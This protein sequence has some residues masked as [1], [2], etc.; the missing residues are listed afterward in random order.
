MSSDSN[1]TWVCALEDVA[2]LRFGGADTLAF[3]QTKLAADT[4][5]WRMNGGGYSVAT[6]IN[7]RILFDGAF[8]IDN[9]TVLGVLPEAVADKAAAHLDGYVIME[10]VEI[11]REHGMLVFAVGGPNAAALLG[12]V[13]LEEPGAARAIVLGDA[14]PKVFLAPGPVPGAAL[15]LGVCSAAD[16]D[17]AMQALV[18][19]GAR[20]WSSAKLRAWEV[21]NAIPR[22]GRDVTIDKTLPLEAGLWNGV[23]LSKGCYLG[24]EVLERLFSR[25]NASRRLFAVSGEGA[26][27]DAGATI[28]MDDANVGEI[29]AAT[30]T[31]DGW[32]G[33]AWIKRKAFGED[34]V[35]RIGVAGPRLHV[36]E[37]VG[38]PDPENP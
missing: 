5:R 35:L 24:Q 36:G 25:G 30:P 22:L 3:L 16:R 18:A 23:S 19:G 34:A 32:A 20:E 13:D 26:A 12:G 17:L 31:E 37:L 28:F 33:M 4:R 11:E 10:D 29:T 7:G 6:D 9:G 14:S 15:W 1:P 8:A 2:V 38:G 27:P 21:R